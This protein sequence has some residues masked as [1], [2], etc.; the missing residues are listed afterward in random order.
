MD[1]ATSKGD[2]MTLR[3]AVLPLGLVVIFALASE[4]RATPPQVEVLAKTAKVKVRNETVGTVKKGE[5]YRLL[6]TQGPWVAIAIGEGEKQRRGWVLA[7]AVK[8]VADADVTEDSA[9]PDEPVEIRM[10]IDLVQF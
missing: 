5:E 2:R 6:K 4:T 7:R 8:L 9:A 10:T 1:S 3:R